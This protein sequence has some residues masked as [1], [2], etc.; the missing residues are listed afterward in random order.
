MRYIYPDSDLRIN[1]PLDILNVRFFVGLDD[2]V[3]STFIN[4]DDIPITV[5]GSDGNPET[6][7]LKLKCPHYVGTGMFQLNGQVDN[8]LLYQSKVFLDPNDNVVLNRFNDVGL[9]PDILSY[10]SDSQLD[11]YASLPTY[12]EE[13]GNVVT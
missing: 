6:S 9:A 2:A 10:F 3:D 12:D 7:L 13:N 8:P 4:F 5:L 11:Y 1:E